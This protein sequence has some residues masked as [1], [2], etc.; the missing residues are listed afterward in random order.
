MLTIFSLFC[1][2]ET[3]AQDKLY[4][5]QFSIDDI[6]LLD[7]KFK[8]AMD[9]NIDVLMSYDMDRLLQPFYREAGLD[10]GAV[11]FDNWADLSGQIG[12]HYLSALAIHDAAVKD[13]VK[14]EMLKTRLDQMI[15][16]LKICQDA[17]ET[18]GTHMIGFLGGIPNSTNMWHGFS[19]G[20]F[21]L[22]D[23]SWVAWYNIN[24]ISAGLRYV[25]V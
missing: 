16:E 10:N 5:D 17:S 7:G 9:L 25:Y 23:Q 12:G 14:K 3:S 22:S 20:D 1:A 6:T 24:K 4:N 2:N 21:T 19:T 15:K 18:Q 11:G 13:P 8:D